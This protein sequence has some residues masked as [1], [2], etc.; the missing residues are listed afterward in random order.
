MI[1]LVLA[2]ALDARAQDLPCTVLASADPARP[3]RVATGT[4]TI[5]GGAVVIEGD[6]I[7]AVGFPAA[8]GVERSGA[9]VTWNGRPCAAVDVSG[10]TVTPGF[11][12]VG[13]GLGVV[14]I[15]GESATRDD[16]GEGDPV[17]AALRVS[18]AYN[19]LSVSIPVGRSGGV[20]STVV[21]PEGGLVSG[22]AAWADLAGDTQAEAVK[23][24]SVALVAG[25]HGESR[26]ESLL[27]LRE[28]LDDAEYYDRRKT[29]FDENR[30]RPL[31][32]SRLDLEALRPVLVGEQPLVVRADRAADIE[33]FLRLA[34]ERSLRLIVSGGSEAWRVADAL[35]AADVP[36]ILDPFVYGPGSFDQVHAR[37]DNAALLA[38]AGVDVIVS[39]FW[40]PNVRLIRHSAGDAV[41]NG[42]PWDVALRA[43]TVAPADAF[44]Q[45]DLGR[46]AVGA[47]AN[48]VVWGSVDDVD[49]VDP[50]E[51]SSKVDALWI[52]G[53]AMPLATRQTELRDKYT[54]L[55]GTP[56]PPLPLP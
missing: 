13:T 8:I 34:E 52:G 33:A 43:L 45:P 26:A 20:T 3:G 44:G 53:E 56:L 7:A 2:L 19:P 14:E 24:P 4:D 35:A 29:S 21:F 25:F 40:T 10:K 17:R 49:E 22:Q 48:V 38:A 32:A 1:A 18:D 12:A 6:R 9:A 55:P 41:R 31:S 11:V 16:A 5:R 30:A 27:R 28:V 23:E 37:P 47:T 42:L 15:S 36:V 46:L 54:T 39:N 50:F 51:T